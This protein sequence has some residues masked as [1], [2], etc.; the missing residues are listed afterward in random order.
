MRAMRFVRSLA[1]AA[2]LA[3][4]FGA[5]ARADEGTKMDCADLDVKIPVPDFDVACT[6]FSGAV[7]ASS[8]GRLKAERLTAISEKQGQFIAVWDIRT[9]G[10]TYIPRGGLEDDVRTFFSEE[11]GEWKTAAPVADFELAQYVNRRSGGNEEECIAFRR[12]MQRRSGGGVSGFARMVLGIGCTTD[13]R[14]ALIETLKQLD[15][16][17]G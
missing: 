12:Q 2:V 17:G 3:I 15:A 9:L 8:L 4:L 10:A 7:S 16:P 5:A 11:M 13:S 14:E 1:A 6:D